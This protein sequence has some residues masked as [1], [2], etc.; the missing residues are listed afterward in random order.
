MVG[1]ITCTSSNEIADA[2]RS[3]GRSEDVRFSP[4]G[5][6]LAVAGYGR[7]CIALFD[8]EISKNGSGPTVALT[9]VT[10]FTSPYLEKPHGVD[11]IDE[12]TLAVANRESDVVLF[13]VPPVQKN[14]RSHSVSP[15]ARWAADETTGLNTPGSVAVARVDQ[16]LAEILVCNNYSHTVTRHIWDRA[17]GGAPLRS[18]VLLQRHINIPDSVSVSANGRWIAISN[19]VTH[20]VLIYENSP[21]L[22]SASEPDAILRGVDYPHGVRFSPDGHRVFVADAGAPYVYVYSDDSGDW[23]GVYHPVATA[24]VL[25]NA[26]FLKGRINPEEGGAKGLDVG[27]AGDVLAVT[28]E[29]QPLTFFDVNAILQHEASAEWTSGKP[30]RAIAHELRVM[31][32]PGRPDAAQ[33][34]ELSMLRNRVNELRDNLEEARRNVEELKNDAARRMT[35]PFRRLQFLFSRSSES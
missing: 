28:S 9:G 6:R 22:N 10:E 20:N 18:E 21:A 24:E 27:P 7:N 17:R 8:I 33:H 13:K 16:A 19:H 11:F 5:R 4:G 34:A 2:I 1:E 32:E 29:Y 3:L 23:R 30:D 26:T 35:N 25:D 14:V 12:E 15:I 31:Q